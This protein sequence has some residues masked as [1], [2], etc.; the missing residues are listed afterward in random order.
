VTESVAVE[1]LDSPFQKTEQAADATEQSV[2]NHASICSLLVASSIADLAKE[3]NNG[4]QQTAQSDGTKAVCQ[5]ALGG[6]SSGILGEVVRVE[7]PRA[8][9]TSDC[10]VDRVLDPLGEP[11]HGEGDEGDE[12]ND[13]ALATTTTGARG[14]IVGGLIL[15][16]DSDKSD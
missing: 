11:V 7:V 10:R 12:T 2:T 16:V 4:D 13:L 15:D 5:G 14:V 9:Y 3:L 6:S 1:E 8:V